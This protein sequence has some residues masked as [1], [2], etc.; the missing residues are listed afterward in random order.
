M[1]LSRR[2]LSAGALAALLAGCAGAPPPAGAPSPAPA[3][4]AASRA[5]ATPAAEF[6]SFVLHPVTP[7]SVGVVTSTVNDLDCDPGDPMAVDPGP[8]V[9]SL[10]MRRVPGGR[11]SS[12]PN[13]CPVDPR[14][15]GT[16]PFG[17]YTTV[18]I[19]GSS[20]P[21]PKPR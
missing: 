14:F 3:A 18:Q 20:A 19:R 10:S 2:S 15:Q 16:D 17:R 5:G 8:R 21:A 7:V 1:P 9:D 12:M 6:W 4:G 11:V 13:A